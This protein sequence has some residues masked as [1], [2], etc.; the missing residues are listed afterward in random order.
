MDIW[1]NMKQEQLLN[2]QKYYIIGGEIK[3]IEW[4]NFNRSGIYRMKQFYETYKDYEN[5][6]TCWNKLFGL[7]IRILKWWSSEWKN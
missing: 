3:D 2:Y 7:V 6:S 1:E 4:N 5:V